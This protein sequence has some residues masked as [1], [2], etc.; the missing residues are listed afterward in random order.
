LGADAQGGDEASPAAARA[1]RWFVSFPPI[2]AIAIAVV[3][4]DGLGNC[5]I[6]IPLWIAA[7][8][9]LAAVALFFRARRDAG[10]AIALAAIV[11][12]ATVPVHRMLAPPPDPLGLSRFGDGA[13]LTVRGRLVREADRFP[14]K[15]RLYVAAERAGQE[16]EPLPPARGL[17]RVTVLRRGPFRIGDEVRFHGRIRFPR[18][19]GDPGEFDYEAFM[20]RN[21]I[22]A[23]MLALAPRGGGLAVA[24]LAHRREFPASQIESVRGRIAAFIDRNLDDPVASE[25]RALVIG[26]RGGIS[27]TMHQTFART[28][29]AH[30]LVI[31]GL[32]L[33]MVAAVIFAAVRFILLL[34]PAIAGRGWANRGAAL[35][36]MVA[37]TAY[38]A[39]AG[40]HV[41]TIRALVM[42]LAYMFAVAIGRPREALASLALAAIVICLAL[43]GSSA[44]VG[45][46]LSFASVVAIVLGMRRYAAWVERRRFDRSSAGV[47]PTHG[48]IAWEWTLGYVAVSFWAMLAVTPL[49]AFYFNQFSLVGLIA[50]A[51][52]VPIMGLGG[53]VLGLAACA[54]SFVWAGPAGAI[55]R[56]AGRFVAAGNLLADWF[57]NWPLAW[58]RVFTP[59][60]VELALAYGV[61]MVWLVWPLRWRS[62]R[63]GDS[64]SAGDAGNRRWRY[65]VL[66]ALFGAIVVDSGWWTYQRYFNPD[67]RVTF[68]SVGEGD[69]A[70]VRFPGSRVML[71]DAGGGWHDFD[72]GER[73]VARYLWSLKIMHVDWLALSHPDRDHF[74]GF[75]FIARNFSP[76][77]FWT[78]GL[79]SR[80]VTYSELLATLDALNVPRRVVDARVAPMHIGGV[81]VAV[82]NPPAR[83]GIS[84][85]NSS[86]VLRLQ[87]GATSFLFTGDLEAAGERALIGGGRR[88][89]ALI[90]KVP[91]HGSRT[92]SSAQFVEAVHPE[93]VVISLGYH[94]RFH[95]PAAEVVDRYRQEGAQLLRTDRD[96]AVIVDATGG[97]ATLR[98]YRRAITLQLQPP[99]SGRP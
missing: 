99:A 6:S 9:G 10:V 28:G 36:A 30:L 94:N 12:A 42:V 96:G 24:I 44:D 5:G 48:E 22:A 15:M 29:M 64:S 71:V 62:E 23:T 14:D 80:D 73:I 27:R 26:D 81:T 32:H 75:G 93:V 72:M 31:S 95:F 86:M 69:G 90:L 68:L 97:G 35:A 45:F 38:A 84:P 87:F 89:D 40:H 46:E 77:A 4:G 13:M 58:S 82:L 51:V 34:F 7:A 60:A 19:F 83:A 47:A 25:M 20:A 17:I 88:L 56:A 92:S 37:V 3:A 76:R 57:V 54:L 50:N 70:V 52:V 11:A 85:N 8:L 98:A 33:S 16:T 43:P 1:A 41:S 74:G 49:T 55:L 39:I 67:L 18:N 59:T 63:G 78:D 61:L 21:G 66:A 79:S 65:A 2:Y 53:T 91:H